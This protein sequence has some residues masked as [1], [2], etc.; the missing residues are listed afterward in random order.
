M[1]VKYVLVV[2]FLLGFS[3][4]LW[5]ADEEP[6]EELS[7]QYV[8]KYMTIIEFGLSKFVFLKFYP[9]FEYLLI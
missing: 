6:P 7:I 2:R 5:N 9:L 1:A 3:G 4:C 8:K